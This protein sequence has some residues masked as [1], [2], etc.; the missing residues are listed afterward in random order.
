MTNSLCRDPHVQGSSVTN[1]R[2]RN[3][4]CRDP[5][6]RNYV[7]KV[8]VCRVPVLEGSRYTEPYLC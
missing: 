4:M 2:C 8:P 5:M 1:P 7:C 6:C 3:P